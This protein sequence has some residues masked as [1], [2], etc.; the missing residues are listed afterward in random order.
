MDYTKVN[1]ALA[2]QFGPGQVEVRE[3]TDGAPWDYTLWFVEDDPDPAT[4]EKA[5]QIVDRFQPTEWHDELAF[6]TEK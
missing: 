2:K 4:I 1:Q 3:A 5:K 6:Q